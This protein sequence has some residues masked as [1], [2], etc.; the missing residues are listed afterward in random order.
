MYAKVPCLASVCFSLTRSAVSLA[1]V[2]IVGIT[3]RLL[4]RHKCG[5]VCSSTYVVKMR[6]G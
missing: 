1:A 2:G 4:R 5:L 3:T 6:D